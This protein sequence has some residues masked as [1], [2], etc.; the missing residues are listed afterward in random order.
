MPGVFPL[1]VIL[2]ESNQSK[3]ETLI[4]TPQNYRVLKI[5]LIFRTQQL[6]LHMNHLG[7]LSNS[8]GS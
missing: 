5:F 7:L 2:N 1:G 6:S 4:K 8:L 3:G